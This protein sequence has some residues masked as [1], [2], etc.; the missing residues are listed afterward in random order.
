MSAPMYA[1]GT[2]ILY[3]RRGVYEIESLGAPPPPID[4]GCLYYKLRSPFSSS[5]EIIYT[6]VDTSAFMRPLISEGKVSEYLELASR[7][8]P[9]TF[10][11]RKT[12]DLAAHYRGLLASCELEDCLLLIKEICIKQRDLAGR[13]KK[14]GQVDQQYLKLAERLVCEEFAAVLHTTPDLI[15]QRLY[16]EMRRKAAG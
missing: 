11:S 7:L 8:E 13:S 4:D 15:K 9:Q 14:L 16:M 10:V 6:P 3:D 2:L 1:V 12:A 5:N